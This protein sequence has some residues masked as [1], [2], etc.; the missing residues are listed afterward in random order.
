MLLPDVNVLVYAHRT[1][2][3]DHPAYASWLR[4]LV[5]GREPFA[6]SELVLIGFLRITTNVRAFRVPTPS[7]VAMAFVDEIC[8]KPGCRLV[9]PGERHLEIFRG[10]YRATGAVG[11]RIADLQHAAVAIEHGCEW[12]TCD[13]DFARIPDLR[14]R[15]PLQAPTIR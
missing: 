2:A 5:E 11:A 12:V 7:D 8:R 1:D 4:R 10:L 6:M 3:E 15:H 13:A 9:R 14:W